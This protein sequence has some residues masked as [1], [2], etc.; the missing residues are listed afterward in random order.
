MKNCFLLLSF[1]F[2]LWQLSVSGHIKTLQGKT[3]NTVNEPKPEIIIFFFSSR[4]LSC[5]ARSHHKGGHHGKTNVNSNPS[6]CSHLVVAG[7]QVAQ[8][9][10]DAGNAAFRQQ[11]HPGWNPAAAPRQKRR[12][13]DHAAAGAHGWA[14]G[15][16]FLRGPA[17]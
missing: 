4:V 17:R 8:L 14:G 2:F 6:V 12:N 13:N 5:I 3:G 11:L 1:F 9:H 16:Q 7:L 15:L 10:P